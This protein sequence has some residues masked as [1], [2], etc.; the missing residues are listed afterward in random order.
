MYD[1][2]HPG[3]YDGIYLIQ[4]GQEV[5]RALYH[6]REVDFYLDQKRVGAYILMNSKRF[7]H[8]IY[9]SG[10][11]NL[12]DKRTNTS[13]GHIIIAGSSAVHVVQKQ[14]SKQFFIDKTLVI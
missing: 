11:F 2:E 1:P 7:C 5:M 6:F 9:D 4:M 3:L 12:I 14:S 8:S 13:V 10:I